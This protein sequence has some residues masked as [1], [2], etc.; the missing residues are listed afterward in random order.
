MARSFLISGQRL[1]AA[2]AALAVA[3]P[4]SAFASSLNDFDLMVGFRSVVAAY[5]RDDGFVCPDVKRATPA[6]FDEYGDALM[7]VVCGP[8][9]GQAWEHAVLRVTAHSEGDFSAKR[10][11]EQAPPAKTSPAQ[12][13]AAAILTQD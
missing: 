10:W 6:G 7:K 12:R 2:L 8:I 11:R 3:A 5:V 9:S 1:R 4:G 13:Q